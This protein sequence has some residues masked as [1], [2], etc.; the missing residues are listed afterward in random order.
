MDPQREVLGRFGTCFVGRERARRKL[1]RILRHM[2]ST[3]I[4]TLAGPPQNRLWTEQ[5][6]ATYFVFKSASELIE[7]HP[8]FPPPLPLHIRGR[9]WRPSDVLEWANRLASGPDPERAKP[10]IP[11]FDISS[12]TNMQEEA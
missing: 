3:S 9:R 1:P 12:F 10:A 2:S 4:E 7:R 8:D 11:E 6:I 5:D